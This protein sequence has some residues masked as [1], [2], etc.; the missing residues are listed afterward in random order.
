[1]RPSASVTRRPVRPKPTGMGAEAVTSA[2]NACA[3]R[4]SL[5]IRVCAI[6]LLISTAL[7]I[8][9]HVAVAPFRFS[10]DVNLVECLA[11][12]ISDVVVL[13]LGQRLCSRLER[14]VIAVYPSLLGEGVGIEERVARALRRF[15]VLGICL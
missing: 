9:E 2:P 15:D 12:E 13:V 8:V 7:Q 6:A 14:I 3:S 11:G 5:F 1:M 4:S 10:E